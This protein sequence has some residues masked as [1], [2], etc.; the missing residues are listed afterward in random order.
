MKTSLNTPIC[1]LIL[2]LSCGSDGRAQDQRPENLGP[3]INTR[4]ID[5]SPLVSPDG[6]TLYFVRDDKTDRGKGDYDI[7][8][9]QMGSDGAWGEAQKMGS[10]LNNDGNNKVM[11][12]T[13]DGNTLY[14]AGIYGAN[15]TDKRGISVIH[16][17]R[18]GWS[19]PEELRFVRS[20]D[21]W[22]SFD[23]T[24]SSDGRTMIL[25]LQSDLWVSF[26]GPD[27]VWSE[28]RKIGPKINTKTYEYTPFLAA[29]N[30]TLYFSSDGHFS[31]GQNDILVTKRLDDTWLRWSEPRN[32][33]R[34]INSPEWESYFRIPASGDYAYVLS[35]K[36]GYGKADIFR[37]RLTD[38]QRPSAVVLVRGQVL[39]EQTRKPLEATIRFELLGPGG[40]ELGTAVTDPRTGEYQIILPGGSRYGFYAEAEGYV[41]ITENLDLSSL[42]VYREVRKDLL[43]V[44]LKQG[45]VV[46]LNNI[47]FETA[48]WDLQPESFSE[49]DR[50]VS[51][52]TVN[53]R[54]QIEIAGHTDD[55]GSDASN[56]TLSENRARSVRTYLVE[57]GIAPS[58]LVSR[59]YGESKPVATNDTE[60]GRQENRRVEFKVMKR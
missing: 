18:D 60:E 31:Y 41:P 6:R 47:F 48:K 9:S 30:K 25:S 11:A 22:G 26:V 5:G 19:R 58:R 49:L 2:I 27:G 59:G 23:M 55:I 45:A 21:D 10:G 14:I 56:K 51:L 24:L 1:T 29:D 33:G 50:V 8:Y 32:L 34:P 20:P 39:D 52:L 37:I 44:Q 46:R 28:P 53:P 16:R 40:K 36:G 13:P 35:W 57:K 7:W 42:T 15:P 3:T 4:H 12:I 17:T 43:M 54:M 38:D